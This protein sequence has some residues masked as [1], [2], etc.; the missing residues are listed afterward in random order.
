MK[1]MIIVKA[2][3][4]SEAGRFPP[5][6]DK[7]FAA[8]ADYHEQLS[9]AGVLLDGSGPAAQQQGLAHP[10]RRRQAHRHR[11]PVRRN[12]GTDR[13]LHPDPGAQPRRGA[14][15]VAPLPQP[16]RR[17]PAGRDRGAAALRDGR[18]QGHRL[19]RDSSSASTRWAWSEVRAMIKTIAS[20]SPPSPSACCSWSPRR[21]PTPSACSAPPASRPRR[22]GCTPLINDMRVFNTWNPYNLKDPNVQGEYQRPAGRPRRHLPLRGQ[23]GRGQGQHRHR[24]IHGAD[25]GHHEARHDRAL[26]RPQHRGVHARAERRGDRTSRGRCTGPAR[27]WPSSWACS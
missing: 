16:G 5:D 15:M 21:S 26:R 17:E 13:R 25:T 19:A 6:S 24:A 23:Q 14:G 27:S 18:F 22:T 8:M 4:D 20:S 3:P 12:Q 9:K 2:T 1:F 11:R 7:L 10:L